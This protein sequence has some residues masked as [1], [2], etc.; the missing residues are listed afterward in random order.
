MSKVQGVGIVA[1]LNSID[2]GVMDAIAQ[3][4]QVIR[5]PNTKITERMTAANA[6]IKMKATF[7]KYKKNNLSTNWITNLNKYV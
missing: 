2:D 1:I 6:L 7:S 3:V 5:N 4:K